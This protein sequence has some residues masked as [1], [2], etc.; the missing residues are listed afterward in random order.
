MT[1][2]A[3]MAHAYQY[4]SQLRRSQPR[5]AGLGRAGCASVGFSAVMVITALHD[6]RGVL[7]RD[8]SY[9]ES[10][11]KGPLLTSGTQEA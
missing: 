9:T 5:V 8:P 7:A 4:L 10:V 3:T 11:K 6:G 2:G 1:T